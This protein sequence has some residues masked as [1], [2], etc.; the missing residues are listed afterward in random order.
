MQ[1]ARVPL[2]MWTAAVRRRVT[3]TCFV[4]IG[5][6]HS[7]LGRVVLVHVPVGVIGPLGM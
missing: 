3:S 5:Y 2:A 1:C 7:E 6:G 4:L